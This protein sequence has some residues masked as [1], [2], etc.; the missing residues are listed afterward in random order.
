VWLFTVKLMLDLEE[1]Q[2]ERLR[3]IQV[4]V[5]RGLRYIFDRGGNEYVG[6]SLLGPFKEIVVS[7]IPISLAWN[8]R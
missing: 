3:L 7:S 4:I 8:E 2:P 5:R 6:E 1:L